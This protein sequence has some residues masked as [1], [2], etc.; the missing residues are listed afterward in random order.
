MT[1][2]HTVRFRSGFKSGHIQDAG[3]NARPETVLSYELGLKSQYLSD[4]LRVNA[5]LFRA[6]YDDLQFSGQDRRDLDGDGIP[7]TG[8]STVVRNASKATID[9][10]EL[11]VQWGITDA[12][13]LQFAAT[14]TKGEFKEFEI[15][16]SVFRRSVQSVR[17]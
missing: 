13:V 11:E 12:D 8:S 10:V 3:N 2:W 5:A 6:D 9:G 14:L 17:R 16:D 1:S 15:P 4:S 7:D